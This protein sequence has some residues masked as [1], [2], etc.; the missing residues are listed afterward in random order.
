VKK[1]QLPTLYI[2][3]AA[4]GIRLMVV[5]FAPDPPLHPDSFIYDAAARNILH[6]G[7]FAFPG[8]KPTA[9]TVPG[10]SIFLS[11]VY[12]VFGDS[13]FTAAGIIQAILSVLIVYFIFRIYRAIFGNGTFAC[14]AAALYALYVP[15]SM[16]N[17]YILT[18][19]LFALL[20]VMFFFFFVMS[21]RKTGWRWSLLAGLF[22]GLGCLVRPVPFYFPVFT[23]MI[24]F[25]I[26]LF[27]GEERKNI[28]EI[29]RE[30]LKRYVPLYV[31]A[32]LTLC[33]W[34]VRNRL[35]L[36][37][38]ILFATQ[39][40]HPFLKGTYYN[41]GYPYEEVFM[42]DVPELERN[43]I[44][45]RL[46]KEHF[47]EEMR[48]S[49]PG[50]TRW[51]LSKIPEM[52]KRP[53][54]NDYT[55]WRIV[56]W[57]T[58][59]HNLLVWLCWISI[60]SILLKSN[61]VMKLPVI[62]LLYHTILHVIFLGFTRYFFTVTP[63]VVIL[64]SYGIYLVWGYAVFIFKH[65][66]NGELK[67]GVCMI[68]LGL[69][70]L[71]FYLLFILRNNFRQSSGIFLLDF[72]PV[73]L[74]KAFSAL[75]SAAILVYVPLVVF[76]LSRIRLLV[77]WRTKTGVLL[78]MMIF[79]I[80]E[81]FNIG[82]IGVNGLERAVC[83]AAPLKNGDIAEHIIELPSWRKGYQDHRLIVRMTNS[84][85]NP[86]GY[87]LEILVNG[88]GMR[89][90]RRGEEMGAPVVEIPL[91]REIVEGNESLCVKIAVS[92]ESGE[93]HPVLFG[94]TKVFRGKSLFNGREDDL[95]EDPGIQRGSYDIGVRLYG[96]GRWRNV[97]F[98][99]GA[100]KQD[101]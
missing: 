45:W 36:G 23:A 2:L 80:G 71:I 27:H 26:R 1:E 14:I 7:T 99:K 34:V 49:P 32:L 87:D 37:K 95:S 101:R 77:Y 92:G 51:Y 43:K 38:Y 15:A 54:L 30:N 82:P 74:S 75:V 55:H 12:A 60:V 24:L 40:G 88:I 68:S 96:K 72:H 81:I 100:G 5:L 9:F 76:Y 79:C 8:T 16:A 28:K 50:Y 63:M 57:S 18:E 11:G 94:T 20:F 10:Y 65:G 52:W 64:S 69:A 83:F 13:N 47:R 98:W 73:L 85:K 58:V 89:V 39:S 22:L 25:A 53:Y 67:P 90:F 59:Q 35:V 21:F 6:R 78:F 93:N 97:Y 29:I 86:L 91:S 42:S 70:V 31:A 61:S 48:K 56:K 84:D 17:K 3:A 46:A 19:V 66:K 4:L 41:Y 62:L 33:P 44:W